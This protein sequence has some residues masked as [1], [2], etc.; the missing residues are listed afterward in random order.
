MFLYFF[1][2]FCVTVNFLKLYLGMWQNANLKGCPEGW[3]SLYHV[4][5]YLHVNKNSLCGLLDVTVCYLD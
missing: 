3:Q 2:K 1:Y 5:T 4:L